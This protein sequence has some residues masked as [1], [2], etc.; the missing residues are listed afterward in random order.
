LFW[1]GF[2]SS[3]L[4]LAATRYP[5]FMKTTIYILTILICISCSTKCKLVAPAKFS[6]KYGFIDTKG[7][8]HI[9]PIFDSVG[10]FY[11][12]F[13]D[14]YKD[15]KDGV[16]DSKGKIV[17]DYNYDFVGLVEN[18]IA[19]ILLND[20]YNYI[21]LEGKLI[22]KIYFD[23]AEDFSDGLAAVKFHKNGKWGFISKSGKLQIDTIYNYVNDFKNGIA[24]VEL[25]ESNFF[26]DTQGKVIKTKNN[27]VIKKEKFSLIGSANNGTLGR[28]NSIGDTIMKK[29]YKSFGYIQNGKFWFNE[30]GK[31]GVADTTGNIIIKPVY[32]NLSSFSDNGLAL[33]KKNSKYGFIDITGKTVIEFKFDDADNFKY[34]MARAKLNGK[35]GFINVKGN[36]VI[37][38]VFERINH[39]FRPINAR[40]E[41]MYTYSE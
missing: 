27:E 35:W 5:Q 24:N 13:A 32:E 33:A 37:Q 30:N 31:Y 18:K 15:G 3:P 26:I 28:V 1:L 34:G 2:G 21:N 41:S 36:F 12:G 19:L 29:K 17:I 7:K 22:S 16:I 11:K 40:F 8:W 6:G 23:N 25:N 14:V 39:Q 9:K 38:P 4:L 20:K 10:I